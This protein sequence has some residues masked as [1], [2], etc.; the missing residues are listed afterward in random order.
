MQ[1]ASEAALASITALQKR[2][3]SLEYDHTNLE[4]EYNSL[5]KQL[6]VQNSQYET[7]ETELSSASDY[8][9]QM[10]QSAHESLK[11]IQ[12]TRD[13][14]ARLK[15]ELGAS[16]QL[17]ERQREKNA[18]LK[19]ELKDATSAYAEMQASIKEHDQLISEMCQAPAPVSVLRPDE[20]LILVSNPLPEGLLTERQQQ[21]H[22]QMRRLPKMFTAQD[23]ATKK[24]IFYAVTEA[25]EIVTDLITRIRFLEKKRCRSTR[26]AEPNMDVRKLASQQIVLSDDMR[27]FAFA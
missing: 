7:R 13:E 8:A 26:P 23:I 17:L 22:E 3:K 18:L 4:S 11:Q 9:R 19:Q 25:K 21:L 6:D 14:N 15:R 10:L 27:Q 24:E 1:A 16:E 12:A 5:K 2:I 20:A